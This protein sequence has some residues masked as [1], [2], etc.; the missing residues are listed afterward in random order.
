MA[1]GE[2]GENKDIV[3]RGRDE[4]DGQNKSYGVY[5]RRGRVNA[6]QP[7]KF[8]TSMK[9]EPVDRDAIIK[10]VAYLRDQDKDLDPDRALALAL[11][12]SSDALAGIIEKQKRAGL[13]AKPF[14]RS[15][16]RLDRKK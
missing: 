16:L 3:L 12:L 14:L 10:A 5:R 15:G 4:E 7:G 11:E 9:D 13:R 1:G 6:P 2:G 8:S